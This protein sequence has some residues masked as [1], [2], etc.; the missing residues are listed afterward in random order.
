MQQPVSP[1]APKK[2]LS[3]RCS[4]KPDLD[5]DY[6]VPPSTYRVLNQVFALTMHTVSET[7]DPNVVEHGDVAHLMALR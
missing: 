7:P 1:F 4:K 2:K 5:L 3:N 6:F